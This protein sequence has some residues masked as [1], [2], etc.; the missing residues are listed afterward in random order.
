[1]A[2]SRR[3]ACGRLRFNI[4]YVIVGEMGFELR[5][6]FVG[7]HHGRQPGGEGRKNH[8][9]GFAIVPVLDKLAGVAGK[10]AFQVEAEVVAATK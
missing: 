1:L 7:V 5:G 3:Q 9:A 10:G 8:R 6:R 4:E 2:V